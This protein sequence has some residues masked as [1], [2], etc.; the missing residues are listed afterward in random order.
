MSKIAYSVAGEGRGHATRAKTIIDHLVKR[1][2]RVFAFAP[3]FA[4]QFLRSVYDREHR[5]TVREIPGLMFHYLRQRLSFTKTT[6]EGFRYLKSLP[7]LVGRLK[8]QLRE[9]AVDLAITDFEPALPR[10][11]MQSGVPWISVDHQHFLVVSDFSHLPA[12]LRWKAWAMAQVVRQYYHRPAQSVVSSFYFPRLRPEY[13]DVI[14]TGVLLRDQV[15]FA[16]PETGQHLVAYLRR[17]RD[18]RTITALKNCRCEARIYGLGEHPDE[19]N[20]RFRTIS[21]AGFLE[22]LRTCRALISNAGNQ[23]IGEA[24]YLQKPVFVVPEAK[25]FEQEINAR[26]LAETGGGAW[27]HPRDLT[28]SR[29]EEFISRRAEFQCTTPRAKLNGNNATLQ[30]IESMLGL[31]SNSSVCPK[32]MRVPV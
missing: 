24:L 4:Y 9:D 21:E 6:F 22:D 29:F 17:H 7:G 23:L 31:D 16:Q 32:T 14:Q 13:H 5:V 18:D 12:H 19:A 28:S 2:H 15:V 20:L 27:C 1:Q 8:A 11:A 3:A 10:A 25:N 30:V 26:F